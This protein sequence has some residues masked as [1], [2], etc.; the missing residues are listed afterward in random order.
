MNKGA[1]WY[2]PLLLLDF[3]VSEVLKNFRVIRRMEKCASNEFIFK[4]SQLNIQADTIIVP[5]KAS[6]FKLLVKL[7][8]Y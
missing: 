1:W 3:N 6:D 5:P 4:L 8:Y 7:S 2:V